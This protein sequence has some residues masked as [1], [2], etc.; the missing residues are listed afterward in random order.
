VAGVHELLQMN[1]AL[2]GLLHAEQAAPGSGA[3]QWQVNALAGGVAAM[4]GQQQQQQQQQGLGVLPP[5]AAAAVGLPVGGQAAAPA[6]ANAVANPQQQQ[7]VPLANPNPVSADNHIIDARPLL[8]LYPGTRFGVP[9]RLDEC[10]MTVNPGRQGKL[11]GS[12]QP[13]Q[14]V[15]WTAQAYGANRLQHSN[16]T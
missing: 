15:D 8:L 5:A 12:F 13:L 10:W 3:G 2:A 7:P 1:A 9:L 16:S 14:D 4:P 6:A 11:T